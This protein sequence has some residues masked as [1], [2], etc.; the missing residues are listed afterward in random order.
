MV[1]FI[2]FIQQE[3]T[4][5]YYKL[6]NMSILMFLRNRFDLSF[7][8]LKNLNSDSVRIVLAVKNTD[9]VI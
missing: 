9:G 7:L 4:N 8:H 3:F 2:T 1:V 6:Y 5:H